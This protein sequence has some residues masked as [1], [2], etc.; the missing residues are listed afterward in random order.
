MRASQ[1]ARKARAKPCKIMPV[2]CSTLEAKSVASAAVATYD[3]DMPATCRLL[4]AWFNDTYL[5][6]TKNDRYVLRLSRIGG[7]SLSEIH[8]ELALLSHL[9][10]RGLSVRQPIPGKHG[11]LVLKLTAPEGARFLVAFRYQEGARMSW[12][13]QKHSK[14]AGRAVGMLH[15]ASDDFSSRYKCPPLDLERLIDAPMAAIRPFLEGRPQDWSFLSTFA[16]KLRSALLAATTETK[17]LDWGVCHGDLGASNM[18]V[19]TDGR[20]TILDFDSCGPGWRAFDL[21]TSWRKGKAWDSFLKGYTDVRPLKDVDRE[22]L[23]I[24]KIIN[25]LFFLGVHAKNTRYFGTSKTSG[26]LNCELSFFRAQSRSRK[27]LSRGDRL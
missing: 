24:F 15:S 5:L 20:V 23:G 11:E 25:R 19:T 12:E 7:R 16:A 13:N 3:I 18:L 10:T 6:T 8:Y 21:C 17:R 1:F 9:K 14:L 27:L 2:I 4:S 22:S 26:Y